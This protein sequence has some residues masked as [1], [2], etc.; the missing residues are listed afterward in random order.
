MKDKLITNYENEITSGKTHYECE[1]NRF[2]GCLE[3]I[4]YAAYEAE[5]G[6][7]YHSRTEYL[8]EKNNY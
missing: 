5:D 6:S 2:W 7:I 3:M 1:L 4:E 8:N